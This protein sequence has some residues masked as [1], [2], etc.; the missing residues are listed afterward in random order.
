MFLLRPPSPAQIR[1]FLNISR[2]QQPNYPETGWTLDGRLPTWSRQGQH[3]V[4]VGQGAACWERARA[5]LEGGTMF[6]GWVQPLQRAEGYRSGDTV[7]LLVR[8]F[9]PFGR[10]QWGLY[11][12]I[13][14]RVLYRIDEPGRFGFG[15]G[16][17]AG[18]L[19]RGEER[20]LLEQDA[21]GVVWFELMTFSRAAV[22]LA[23]LAQPFVQLAQ[24][25]GAAHYARMLVQAAG[26]F[27][28]PPPI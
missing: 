23:R 10:G 18:H 13:A 20:F 2:S 17:L 24:R 12:L 4:R 25:R 16:T 14:N 28:I 1:A 15:Y 21:A 5:A 3:R 19:V 27:K 6:Q 8:H 22:P 9:G 11:S 26:C 7:A